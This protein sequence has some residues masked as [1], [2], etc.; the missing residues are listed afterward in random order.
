MLFGML[1]L[2]DAFIKKTVFLEKRKKGDGVG[3]RAQI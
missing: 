1:I 3:E 2:E